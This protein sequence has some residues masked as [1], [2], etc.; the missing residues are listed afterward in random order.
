VI[1]AVSASVL[2]L[3]YVYLTA[4]T[5]LL[6]R[7][8]H[9]ALG[10]GGDRELERAIRAHANFAEYVPLS[11]LLILMIEI[12]GG[13]KFIIAFL[14]LLLVSGRSIHAYGVSQLQENFRLRVAGMAMT[15]ASLA[16]A[17]LVNLLYF[18]IYGG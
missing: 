15:L 5:I 9:I 13:S 10:T 2:A 1:T 4:R 18:L 16:L 17:S 11:L 14:G 6:R 3:L 7:D 8:K 12:Q